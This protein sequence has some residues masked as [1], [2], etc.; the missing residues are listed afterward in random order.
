MPQ[1]CFVLGESRPELKNTFHESFNKRMFRQKHN[2]A[3]LV[4]Q[5]V[6]KAL[7]VEFSAEYDKSESYKSVRKLI[8]SEI[9]VLKKSQFA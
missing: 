4:L 6:D 7:R 2:V 1:M 9:G 5:S 8:M 3:L